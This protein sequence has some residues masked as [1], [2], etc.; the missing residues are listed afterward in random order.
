MVKEN[1][2]RGRV[3][4]HMSNA[5]TIVTAEALLYIEFV[6]GELRYHGKSFTEKAKQIF[7]R[8][9]NISHKG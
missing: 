2:R 9:K 8:H 5:A 1:E 7:P 3:R 6:G 4:E